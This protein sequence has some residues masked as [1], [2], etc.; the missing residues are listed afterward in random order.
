MASITIRNLDDEVKDLL[1]RLAAENDRSM[2]EQARVM[3]RA[4]VEGR[5][6][7]IGRIDQIEKTLRELTGSYGPTTPIAAISNQ[8]PRGIL[9]GKRILLIIG[10]GI[11][12]YKSLDL[13]RR[14]RE[15]GA[16]VRV[17]MTSA[18]QEFVTTLSVGALSADHV[19]T[20]LFDRQDEHDVGHIRLSREADLV[21]VAPATA[22]LMAKLANGHANDLASTVLIAT[23]KQVLMAPAM[24]P[25][26]WS[27][28][29]T[30]RNRATLQEDG[31]AFI[32]PAKG[33]MAES[34]EAGEGRMTEP[35]EIVAAI[36]ALLDISP[37]PL[38]GRKIIV[39]SGPTHEPIDPVRYIANRSSGKQG[40]AIAAALA[41]LGADVR[42]VSGPVG[43]AD[44]AEV[45]T[46]HVETANEMKDAVE[47]LLPADAAVFV[48]AVAD[49]RSETSAGEKIKKVAGEGPPVLRMI[50]NPDILA[51]VG[52]HRQRPS[53]VVGFA[54]ETQDLVRNAE[55]KLKKKGAD[56][57]VANDVSHEGAESPGVMGGDRNKV[58]IV[59]KA[60]VD[61]W[62]EMSK[63]EVA[64]RLAAVIA[65]RLKTIVV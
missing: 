25:R 41:R 19:F 57:I 52:H 2:E 17:V 65:E 30:R 23:D 36:K 45:T 54:A 43:I 15:R 58:R 5:L 62:P 37:K 64:A 27:H 31:I 35:L 63:D 50:E 16:L 10:G 6:G 22:D 14:L 18:A 53:L 13:I 48:A 38:S 55:A 28:P 61:E 49:W 46:L 1:R 59:S 4:A 44:P 40:H 60:G 32:G 9:S 11:A 12:A 8:M 7:P 24:N 33:E 29:A 26:M 3:I 34:N 39:T 51:G 21:V 20:E 56:F 47:Q 42:L